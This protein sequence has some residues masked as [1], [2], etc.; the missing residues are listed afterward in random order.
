MELEA[1][2]PYV[3]PG[4][5]A[6]DNLDRDIT[7]R[8]VVSGSVD[9]T[10]VGTYAVKYN[11]TDSQ[12]IPALEKARVVN[13][14]DT[15]PPVIIL[16][17]D[18]PLRLEVGTPYLEPG[19]IAT[20]IC[21][22]DM[23][24]DVV[25]KGSVNH[26]VVG[27]YALQYNVSDWSGN[28]A[29]EKT[30]TVEVAEMTPPVISLLGDNP[31][32]LEVGTPYVEPGYEATDNYDGDITADV[33]VTGSVDHTIPGAYV[34]RYNVCDSSGNA[35]EEKTRTVNVVETSTFELLEVKIP[36]V[37]MIQL[38]WTSRPGATYT[39]WSCGDLCAGVWTDEATIASQGDS[40]GWTDPE[41]A[42]MCKFYR[43]ELK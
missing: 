21:D 32:T 1:G 30:R 43:I 19:Y 25:V 15:T 27:S 20:D 40:T 9:H 23:T 28:P 31:I 42:C 34:L 3:E 38:T 35:A 13:V 26:N 7:A 10:F 2:T 29:E 17:G 22:G 36:A 41:T 14:V 4:F 5:T 37:G 12:G 8:V 24:G 6:V 16:L 11:V 33:A 39:I 18:N